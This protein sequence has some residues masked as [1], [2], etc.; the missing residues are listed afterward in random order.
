MDYPKLDLSDDIKKALEELRLRRINDALRE[1]TR[2]L[3]IIQR[4]SRPD[5][6]PLPDVDGK[7]SL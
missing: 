3:L 5:P 6:E 7:K 1:G 2:R 4:L